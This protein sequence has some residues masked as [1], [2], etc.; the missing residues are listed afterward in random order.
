MSFHNNT[1]PN[2]DG[3]L[4]GSDS[5]RRRLCST[6]KEEIGSDLGFSYKNP[7]L[8][9]E[10]INKYKQ[11]GTLQRTPQRNP[12]YKKGLDSTSISISNS[13]SISI[14]SK[15]EFPQQYYTER[16]W[17]AKWVRFRQAPS[18]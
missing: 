16:G 12:T 1:I 15:Y 8:V 18:L 17:P 5:V 13:D 9:P 4:N 7:C 14:S 3:L 6:Q 10:H 11:D 2:G